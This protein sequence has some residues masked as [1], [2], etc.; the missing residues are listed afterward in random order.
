MR[1]FVI[2]AAVLVAALLGLSGGPANAQ[3]TAPVAGVSSAGVCTTDGNIVGECGEVLGVGFGS[4]TAPDPCRVCQLAVALATSA[5][6]A[7]QRVRLDDDL[8][9]GLSLLG[10]AAVAAKPDQATELRTKA[11]A[12]FTAAGTEIGKEALGRPGAGYVDPDTGAYVP[13]SKGWRI[14]VADGL[15]DGLN[16]L[17]GKPTSKTVAQAMADFDTAYARFV[18]GSLPND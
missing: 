17:R 3:V 1:K 7:A 18:A 16:L 2:A 14:D 12:A 5:V 11:Q 9:T 8:L 10:Q 6:P 4:D 13:L 15:T